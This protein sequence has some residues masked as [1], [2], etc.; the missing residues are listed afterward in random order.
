[1][2]PGANHDARVQRLPQGPDHSQMPTERKDSASVVGTSPVQ[3]TKHLHCFFELPGQASALQLRQNSSLLSTQLRGDTGEAERGTGR[4]PAALG[5]EQMQCLLDSHR[6]AGSTCC[7]WCQ[8]L[9]QPVQD[10]GK[11]PGSERTGYGQ[12]HLPGT[13]EGMR[14]SAPGKPS[15]PSIPGYNSTRNN[16]TPRGSKP[17]CDKRHKPQTHTHT[18]TRS[19]QQQEHSVPRSLRGW[20]VSKGE[21]QEKCYPALPSHRTLGPY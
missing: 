21:G 16:S 14:N 5:T 10:G 9:G 8:A 11:T 6:C 3:F 2:C 17:R 12:A 7:H 1:M 13:P 15:Y 4:L 20:E 18:H 19:K